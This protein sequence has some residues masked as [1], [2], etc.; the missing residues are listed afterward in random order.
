MTVAKEDNEAHTHCAET[1]GHISAGAV[2]STPCPVGQ[3]RDLMTSVPH[4]S[5]KVKVRGGRKG[6]GSEFMTVKNISDAFKEISAKNKILEQLS[7]KNGLGGSPQKRKIDFKNSDTDSPSKK[8]K[9][10]TT[11]HFWKQ[12]E[13]DKL[14]DNFEQNTLMGETNLKP[15]SPEIILS[16]CEDG[17][18]CEQL[19]D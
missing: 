10:E 17:I 6:K 13:G 4:I 1:V 3:D 11:R 16:L 7:L 15:G 19:E 18:I 12:L 14:E 5:S 2:P 8:T 9:F